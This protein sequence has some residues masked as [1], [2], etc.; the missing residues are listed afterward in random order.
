FFTD[1]LLEFGTCESN[2]ARSFVSSSARCSGRGALAGS[3]TFSS[4][5]FRSEPNIDPL[6]FRACIPKEHLAE[7][8]LRAREP[9]LDGVRRLSEQRRDFGVLE[10]IAIPE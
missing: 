6:T 5:S 3:K 10:A 7:R 4:S 2:W 8:P 9:L 1:C